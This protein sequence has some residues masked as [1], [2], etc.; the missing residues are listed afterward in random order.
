MRSSWSCRPPIN[1]LL[2]G[3]Q[4]CLRPLHCP[5]LITPL[6]QPRRW[7]PSTPPPV[8]HPHPHT[9]RFRTRRKILRHSPAPPQDATQ[10]KIHPPYPRF[11]GRSLLP[12]RPNFASSGIHAEPSQTTDGIQNHLIRLLT[13][14]NSTI[15]HLNS[16]IRSRR[17]FRLSS[18][19][20][21]PKCWIQRRNSSQDAQYLFRPP[22]C[23]QS[24]RA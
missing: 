20:V 19:S 11:P 7:A 1:L 21:L 18:S 4:I 10:G 15:S 6:F 12:L 13:L 2:R 22:P 23:R 5:I 8:S 14:N 9:R 17:S 16:Q 24:S 3:P